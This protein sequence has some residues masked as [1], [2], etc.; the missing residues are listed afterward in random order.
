MLPWIP[1]LAKKILE[2][3]GNSASHCGMVKGFKYLIL[4]E[5]VFKGFGVMTSH[6]A[7]VLETNCETYLR[8]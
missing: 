8:E 7:M 4:N 2:R 3:D 6:E 5:R 1:H